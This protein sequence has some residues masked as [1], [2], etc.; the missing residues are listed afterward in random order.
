MSSK[1][2]SRT[3]AAAM[4]RHEWHGVDGQLNGLVLDC[5]SHITGY[6]AH[7]R[8]V[9]PF[10]DTDSPARITVREDVEPGGTPAPLQAVLKIAMGWGRLHPRGTR[11]EFVSSEEYPNVW[12]R[13]TAGIEHE[14]RAVPAH[15]RVLYALWNGGYGNY[16][17][18]EAPRDTEVFTSLQAVKDELDSRRRTGWADITRPD[19]STESTRT[20]CVGDDS[21]FL[22]WT[23]GDAEDYP[24]CGTRV[25]FGPRGGVRTESF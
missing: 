19:G 1:F 2:N 16:S 9:G 13:F 24:E 8:L 21:E 10:S 15:S 3:E 23:G 20:P 7:N 6:G 25:F 4:K 14:F 11:L 5:E 18:A 12:G 17:P 22:V